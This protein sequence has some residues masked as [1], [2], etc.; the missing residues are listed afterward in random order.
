[1]TKLTLFWF[2]R[3]LRLEDNAGL[4]HALKENSNV[5][6]LFIFD[7]DI[8]NK[9]EDRSDARVTFIYETVSD[10]KNQLQKRKSDLLVR[11]GQPLE[12]FKDL[13]QK[14][15]IDAIYTNHDYEPS[16]R[17]RDEKIAKFA[18]TQGAQFKSFKDQT[19]FEKEEILTGMRKPYTVYTPYKNKVLENLSPFYL[20]SYPNDLYEGSYAKVAK[21]E[22]MISLKELGFEKSVLEFPS[23]NLSTKMLKSYEETRNFPA[24]EGGTSH[25]GLHLRFGTVS[26][27]ELAREG[28]KYSD[29]WL[30]ELIWRDFFMQILWHFPQ[31]EN[32]SFRP[33]YD[34]IAWRN[35]TK[36]FERWANGMTGYPIVDAGM[37]ELNATG[38]MHNRVRMVV[39]SFLCKHLLI[40]WYEGERYFAKKLLDFDLSANNGNWQWAAGSGCDAAPYFRIFN[41]TTQAEKFDPENKYIDKW[42][43][44]LHTSKYP[45]PMI[46]HAEAR[47]R[48][49][50]AF[51]KVLKK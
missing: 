49:L 37:R 41:P 42:V 13:F 26:V 40:H 6:P 15:D 39:A 27:R 47:G 10:L 16:A 43:P 45:Q 25:L 46:D 9:L 18:K 34:K 20:K 5:L 4:F 32:T 44:E 50:Q 28:Q 35:S 14:F 31:V 8:L 51:T 17:S 2:R 21:P 11:H 12:I 36:D 3:D 38:Y 7:T 19:L 1:M 33:E 23:L 30:S 48:C 24:L 29:V 22:K